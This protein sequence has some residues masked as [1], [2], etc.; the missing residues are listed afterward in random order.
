[1]NK[2]DTIKSVFEKSYNNLLETSNNYAIKSAVHTVVSEAVED[3]VLKSEIES[4]VRESVL[5]V[6]EE[7]KNG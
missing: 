1:M 3:Y 7:I 5:E 4:I 6:M 2:V